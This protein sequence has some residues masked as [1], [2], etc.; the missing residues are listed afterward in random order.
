MLEDLMV[1]C[2]A[3]ELC[4]TIA[5]RVAGLLQE[6]TKDMQS[7]GGALSCLWEELCVQVQGGPFFCWESHLAEAR[8]LILGEVERLQEH[9]T[10]ALG[11]MVREWIDAQGGAGAAPDAPAAAEYI[12]DQ[13]LLPKAAMWR[14]PQIEAFLSNGQVFLETTERIPE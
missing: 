5:G 7:A 12:L 2:F 14:D 11:I 9:E 4:K 1:Q 10:H 13:Y 3:K 8:E 6:N